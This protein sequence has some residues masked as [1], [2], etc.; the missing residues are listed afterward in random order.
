MRKQS[1]R[2]LFAASVAVVVACGLAGPSWVAIAHGP[3]TTLYF[4]RHGETQRRLVATG[5]GTFAEVCTPT[6]SCCEQPLSPLGVARRDALSD[7]FVKHGIAHR[8]THLI[9]TNKPRTVETLVALALASGLGGDRDGDG[10][11][12]GTDVDLLPGDGI[13]QIPRGRP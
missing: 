13:Q 4:I 12:D 1:A 5:T 8:L 10:V 2:S 11:L 6:R 7:W 9:A 3:V